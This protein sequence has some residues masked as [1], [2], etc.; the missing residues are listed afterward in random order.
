MASVW[1]VVYGGGASAGRGEG[2]ASGGGLA[3]NSRQRTAEL[4]R[5]GGLLVQAGSWEEAC[6]RNRPLA[7]PPQQQVQEKWHL[8]E[9]LSRLLPE[10]GSGGSVGPESPHSRAS[11]PRSF[12]PG[13]P[14]PGS[15][16]PRTPRPGAC[17]EDPA[18]PCGAPVP[19]SR[20]RFPSSSEL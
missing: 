12:C 19:A 6:A 8:V 1:G 20:F 16:G 2:E 15:P 17:L 9:D 11:R 18:R 4:L 7:P 10:P 3:G 14:C 5:H 13:F